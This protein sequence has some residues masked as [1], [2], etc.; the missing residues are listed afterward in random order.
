M[1]K[2]TFGFYFSVENHQ[3]QHVHK[4]KYMFVNMSLLAEGQSQV[5]A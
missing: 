1:R 3:Q 4:H 2:E 5:G